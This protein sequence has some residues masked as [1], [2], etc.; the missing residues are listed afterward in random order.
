MGVSVSGLHELEEDLQK[1]VDESVDGVKAVV[2][3]GLLNIKKDIRAQWANLA[4]APDLPS[5]VNY[6][7]DVQGT[8]VTGEVGPDKDRKQGALGNLLEFGSVNNA[9][10]PAVYPAGDREEPRFIQALE[11]LGYDLLEGRVSRGEFLEY[12]DSDYTKSRG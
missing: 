11:D 12:A 7:I 2:S 3:K 4:H 9:P 5:A 6:D 10:H 8:L 1:A